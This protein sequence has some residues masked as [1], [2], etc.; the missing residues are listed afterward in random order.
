MTIASTAPPRA[1]KEAIGAESPQTT[2]K[3][4]FQT[5]VPTAGGCRIM[6]WTPSDCQ[7]VACRSRVGDFSMDPS[8]YHSRLSAAPV[9]AAANVTRIKP[10]ANETSFTNHKEARLC[11]RAT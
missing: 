5:D 8:D 4:E 7:Y 11:K 10:R 9:V 1:V 6:V 2:K 3:G